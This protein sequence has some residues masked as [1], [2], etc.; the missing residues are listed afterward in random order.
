[1]T[2]VR[3]DK[4]LVE[5]NQVENRSKVKNLIRQKL[6]QVNKVDI[7]KPGFLINPE[8]DEINIKPHDSYVSRS[9]HKLVDALKETSLK[10][11]GLTTADIGAS[12]GGFTQVLLNNGA[13]KVYAI[14]VGTSQ[15]HP[16]I[17]ANSKVE[18][19]ENTNA[20]GDLPIPKVDLMVG[21]L[22]F[23]SAEKYVLNLFKYIERN[24]ALFLLYK[25]QF[26]VGPEN[27]KPNG[28][29]KNQASVQKSLQKFESFLHKNKLNI[30]KIIKTSLPGKRGNQEYFILIKR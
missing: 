12:T 30:K 4:Y 1:M 28:V 25:P 6:I 18:N 20:K 27:L 2:K 16:E 29:V 17:A 22:S 5:T 19:I 24:G 21:D 3:I 13:E 15:L 23:I 10:I 14:D 8:K 9:A 11:E 7:S 26:E